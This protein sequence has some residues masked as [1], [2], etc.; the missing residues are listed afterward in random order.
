MTDETKTFE[1]RIG[2]AASS[3]ATF[4][5]ATDWA[6]RGGHE[7][8][9]EA[10]EEVA[11]TMNGGLAQGLEEALEASGFEWWIETRVVGGEEGRA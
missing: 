10:V 2:W 7:E 3:N 9:A 5:G 4:R 1:Y 11:T 8:T 6:E